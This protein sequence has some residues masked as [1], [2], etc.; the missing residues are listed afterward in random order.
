MKQVAIIGAGIGGLTAYHALKH[1]GIA[2]DLYEAAPMLHEVGAGIVMP[3][4]ALQVLARLGLAES[5]LKQGR[6]LNQFQVQDVRGEVLQDM[7][8]AIYEKQY[9]Y[10]SVGIHRAALQSLLMQGVT[11]ERLH[12]GHTC[13]HISSHDEV[14]EITFSDGTTHRAQVVIAADGI[15]SV[16]RRQLFPAQQLRYAG[17]VAY[18]GVVSFDLPPSLTQSAREIWGRGC[19][20]GFLGIGDRQVDWFAAIVAPPGRAGTAETITQALRRLAALFPDPVPQLLRATAPEAIIQTD[21]YD[22]SPSLKTWHC[23]RVVLLGDAAHATTPN[24]GQGAA[25]AIEDAYV[26]ANTLSHQ[27]TPDAAFRAF[28]RIRRG[29]VN[30]IVRNSWLL[31]KLAQAQGPVAQKVRNWVLQSTPDVVNRWQTN[32]LFRLTF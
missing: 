20:F 7:N 3:S 12:L 9:G 22:I 13:T 10:G 31:G 23:G 6:R 26:L 17:E 16:V 5:L 8:L 25:Q 11:S 15:H 28:E 1:H 24:L 32:R 2:V 19:R 18:R 30:A 29:K 14:A 27:A 4:N 21:L